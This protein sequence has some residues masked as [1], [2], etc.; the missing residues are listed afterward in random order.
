MNNS[1]VFC[2]VAFG[3]EAGGSVNVS[4]EENRGD[5]YYE[6][7]FIA[8]KSVKSKNPQITVGVISNREVPKFYQK[9][10]NDNE[11]QIWYAPFDQFVFPT[12]YKWYLAFYKLT[13]MRWVVNN[14]S[15]DYFIQ[16]DCDVVCNGSLSD[17]VE[18]LQYGIMMLSGPFTY[19]HAVRVLYR[20][21]YQKMYNDINPMIKWGSGLIAGKK[22]DMQVFMDSCLKIHEQMKKISLDKM[23]LVGE[24]Y[25]TSVAA[26]HS[27]LPIRDGKAYMH[28]YWTG[29]FYLVSTNYKYDKIVLLH[30]PDEKEIG[31]LKLFNR[32]ISHGKM[33]SDKVVWKYLGL[34]SPHRIRA[35]KIQIAKLLKKA[36][37]RT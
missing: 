10:F 22:S 18:D 19:H 37:G 14:L 17:L 6:N 25:I 26:I 13:T 30:V 4:R 1:L 16:I 5:I 3:E 11:I 27:G 33:P 8:L 2:C 20:D 31:M 7:A 32:Y 15:F 24:E 12:S 9:L 29:Q 21:I 35:I 36:K 34:S 28:V 23:Q